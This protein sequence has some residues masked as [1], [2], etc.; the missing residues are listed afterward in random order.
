MNRILVAYDGRPPARHALDTAIQLAKSQADATVGVVSVVP[1][2][3]GRHLDDAWEDE[4]EMT[5]VL[6]E[7]LGV[8]EQAGIRAEPLKPWGDP[9]SAIE[10]VA[11]D[12]HYDTIVVGTRDLG[13]LARIFKGS[14]SQH[15]ADHAE[16]T[17]VIAR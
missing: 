16:A 6:I 11:A 13:P 14:V 17:V 7:A 3:L 2:R 5:D 1:Y 10:Q 15:V 9:A 8:L 12:G 4:A